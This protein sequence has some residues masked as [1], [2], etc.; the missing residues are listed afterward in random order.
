MIYCCVRAKES[1]R[2]ACRGRARSDPSPLKNKQSMR[3]RGSLDQVGPLLLGWR[4]HVWGTFEARN[5]G[6]MEK[7]ER[8]R[9]NEG[10]GRMIN[11]HRLTESESVSWAGW[12]VLLVEM[13]C[14]FVDMHSL[15]SL[16]RIRQ[17]LDPLEGQSHRKNEIFHLLPLPPASNASLHLPQFN[18]PPRFPPPSYTH[19][20]SPSSVALPCHQPLAPPP[21]VLNPSEEFC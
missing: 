12:E 14:S 17:P 21:S 18:P 8:C 20:T 13:V 10:V 5:Q 3:R 1:Q 4:W 16:R 9:E 19:T 7:R 15:A 2:E 6:K 11:M